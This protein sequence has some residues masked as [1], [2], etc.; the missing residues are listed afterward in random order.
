M[1][2]QEK[3]EYWLDGNEKRKKDDE[4]GWRLLEKPWEAKEHAKEIRWKR[5]RE[6]EG[7]RKAEK[8]IKRTHCTNSLSSLFDTSFCHH[9]SRWHIPSRSTDTCKYNTALQIDSLSL[10]FIPPSRHLVCI[11]KVLSMI[12]VIANPSESIK[13]DRRDRNRRE[14]TTLRGKPLVW[15]FISTKR[16]T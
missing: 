15:G 13:E 2:L 5:R 14:N 1:K 12:R 7:D 10:S 3:T 16:R 8:R 11:Y 6:D 4:N 9:K